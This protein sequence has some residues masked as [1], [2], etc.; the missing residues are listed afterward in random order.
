[1]P[2][3]YRREGKCC[4][5]EYGKRRISLALETEM[6]LSQRHEWPEDQMTS[7]CMLHTTTALQ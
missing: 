7:R 3:G 2:A 6:S 5:P 1:M 4:Y